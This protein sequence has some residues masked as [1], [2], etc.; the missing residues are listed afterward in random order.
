MAARTEVAINE[1]V[2]GEEVLGL[3]RRFEPLHLPLSS[4][5]W[6]M[7]VFSPII[8]ISALS[9]LDV[10]K[11]L[12]LGDAVAPQL[13][14]HN[15]PRLIMQALQQPL[16][17]ARGSLAITPGLNEDVEHNAMLIHGAPEIMLLA[18]DADENYVD[19]ATCRRGV[20]GGGASGRQNLRRISCTSVAPIHAFL[21]QHNA[22][23]KPF[24]WVKSAD[25][26]LAAIEGFCTYNTSAT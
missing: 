20:A 15:H 10:R 14:S 11:Q 19:N 4:S 16:E 9:V 18:L 3:P 8:Q 17:E 22:N 26:I 23:P 13:V 6:S 25:D 21:G 5:R 7:R 24:R 1:G 2:S 12:T